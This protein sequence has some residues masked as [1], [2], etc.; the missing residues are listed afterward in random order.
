MGH[1]EESKASTDGGAGIEIPAELAEVG[2][3]GIYYLVYSVLP[4]RLRGWAGDDG[5]WDIAIAVLSVQ[6]E[7]GKVVDV[8]YR[9]V[10]ADA[11]FLHVR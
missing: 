1:S 11:G 5:M 10:W 4:V 9:G 7:D 2:F 8:C 6:R 3:V